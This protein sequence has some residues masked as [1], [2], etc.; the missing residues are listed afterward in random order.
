MLLWFQFARL[1]ERMLS[2]DQ[3]LSLT[4]RAIELLAVEPKFKDVFKITYTVK[5]LVSLIQMYVDFSL[6]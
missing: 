5:L 3:D 6:A 1:L 4:L 2:P